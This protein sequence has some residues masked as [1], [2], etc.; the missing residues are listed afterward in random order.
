MR[1]GEESTASAPDGDA[2]PDGRG[3]RS[4][5]GDPQTRSSLAEDAQSARLPKVKH[6]MKSSSRFETG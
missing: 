3:L 1:G 2:G 6:A 5:R 4:S